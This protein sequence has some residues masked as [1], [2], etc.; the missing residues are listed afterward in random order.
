MLYYAFNEALNAE[1]RTP[2][3]IDE[4]YKSPTTA[5][6]IGPRRLVYIPA[7]DGSVTDKR[8]WLQGLYN[9]LYCQVLKN[10]WD[11]ITVSNDRPAYALWS[12][13]KPDSFRIWMRPGY[14][15]LVIKELER[16]DN[17]T[18]PAPV[19]TPGFSDPW[20]LEDMLLQQGSFLAGSPA[21]VRWTGTYSTEHFKSPYLTSA[22]QAT[23]SVISDIGKLPSSADVPA[24]D[25]EIITW[26]GRVASAANLYSSLKALPDLYAHALLRETLENMDAGTLQEALHYRLSLDKGQKLHEPS[27]WLIHFDDEVRSL[28]PLQCNG[29]ELSAVL[30]TEKSP[31]VFTLRLLPDVFKAGVRLLFCHVEPGNCLSMGLYLPDYPAWP[32]TQVNTPVPLASTYFTTDSALHHSPRQV[33]ILPPLRGKAFKPQDTL[34]AD[35]SNTIQSEVYDVSGVVENGVDPRTGLFHAHYPIATVQGTEGLG[36]VLELNIHYSARRANEGALG[37]GWAFRFSSF[38]NRLRLLTLGT[39]QTIQL[40]AAEV[41]QLCKT[42]DQVLDKGFCR[43]S[44][45]IAEGRLDKNLTCLS[46]VT[47]T[48]LSQRVEVLAKPDLHDGQE[49]SEQYR[50]AVKSRLNTVKSNLTHWIDKE[51]ITDDQSKNFKASRTAVEENLRDM[52]RKAFILAAKTITSPQGGTLGLKW[53]GWKGHVRLLSIHSGEHCLLRADHEQPVNIGRYSSTFHVWP[54]TAEA[55]QVTLSIE[56]CLLRTLVRKADDKSPA[57]QQVHYGYQTD[58]ALDRVL[59][60]IREEDGSL[61]VVS[62]EPQVSRPK[63]AVKRRKPE[64]SYSYGEPDEDMQE[65]DSARLDPE[66]EDMLEQDSARLDPEDEDMLEQDWARLGPK[67]EDLPTP[68]PRVMR[69]TF[70]PGAE[71]ETISHR[72]RWSAYDRDPRFGDSSFTST[73]TLEVH[74]SAGA[75][76]TQ[77]IWGVRNGMEVP[78]AI[79]EETPGSIRRITTNTYPTRTEVT[80]DRIR[81]L[82]LSQPIATE[83]TYEDVSEQATQELQS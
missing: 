28:A 7:A 69:H 27:R 43:L 8:S 23:K 57:V 10:N 1:I 38:D 18:R 47:I 62:C 11:F 40:T 50:N 41:Y 54:G 78:V 22:I 45:G 67:D 64:R 63:V 55:Y 48:Y 14:G 79:V 60:S 35:Y 34:C 24:H 19:S 61:E 5:L 3:R 56:D 15:H 49:A 66:D 16:S 76:F 82:L 12:L 68:L 30:T 31:M 9:A 6:S 13:T 44:Q 21:C 58:K 36:P 75:P 53:Q 29:R 37:D 73:E 20:M 80:D 77:R 70:V 4:W 81:T 39:G 74:A 72:W 17:A 32:A 52:S 83:V 25:E 51:D 2:V 65:E 26:V 42:P 33:S 46:S 71:Q 59:C